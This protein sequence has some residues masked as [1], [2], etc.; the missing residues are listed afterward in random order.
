MVFGWLFGSVFTREDLLRPLWLRPLERP[1]V[2]L[3]VSLAFGACVLV[4]GLL[5]DALQHAWAARFRQWCQSRAGMLLAYLGMIGC[6]LSWRSLWVV[7]LGL[8]WFWIGSSL[9]AGNRLERFAQSIGASIESMLQLFVNTLS[10][11][12]V[13]AFALAHAGLAAAIMALA[14]GLHSRTL[15]LVVLIIG[16]VAM[17][18]IEGLIVGI[19]TTR[20]V[21][22]EFFIRFLHGTGRP[23][24]PLPPPLVPAPVR[25]QQRPGFVATRFP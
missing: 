18:V 14:A 21:L 24:R 11:V 7:A 25:T 15:A 8:A 22:F 19:Q 2:P 17:I 16:N 13:G 1:L 6:A 20:L 12:R 4:V 23:F 3:A 10:F 9:K 5:L